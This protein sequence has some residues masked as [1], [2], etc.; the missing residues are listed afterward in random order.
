MIRALQTTTIL[1]SHVG[2]VIFFKIDN[3]V[4]NFRVSRRQSAIYPMQLKGPVLTLAKGILDI[5]G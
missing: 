2:C 4:H 1:P 3:F 5:T